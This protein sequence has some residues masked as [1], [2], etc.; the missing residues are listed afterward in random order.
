MPGG[1]D[2]AV[3]GDR[4]RHREEGVALA[5]H[6]QGRGMNLGDHARRAG[7][8]EQGQRLRVGGAVR[9]QV[10]EGLA[11]RGEQAGAAAADADGEDARPLLLVHAGNARRGGVRQQRGDQAVPGDGRHD[12]VHPRVVG[13]G[14]QGDPAAVGAAGEPHP[15]VARPVEQ[16]PGL[17]GEPGDELLD[18]E[19]LVVGGVEGDLA[20]RVAEPPGRIQQDDVAGPREI[21]RVVAQRV[22]VR[23]PAVGAD[24]GGRGVLRVHPVGHVQRAVEVDLLVPARPVGHR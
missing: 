14:E 2:A 6:E 16:H 21:E 19:H 1:Q 18:V 13:G 17:T 4:L 8:V 20:G 23:A 5:L 12:R 11:H 10:L 22:L 7:P 3:V 15:R 9:P 24:H